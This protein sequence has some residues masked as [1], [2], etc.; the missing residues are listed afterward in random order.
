MRRMQAAHR[1]GITGA[2]AVV[3]ALSGERR[4]GRRMD[5]VAPLSAGARTNPWYSNECDD[6]VIAPGDLVSFDT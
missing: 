3:G 4:A 6:Y 1:P 2:G 5:G